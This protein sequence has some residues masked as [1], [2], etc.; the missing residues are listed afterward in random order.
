MRIVDIIKKPI[1]TEKNELWKKNAIKKQ[2]FDK[3]VFKVS[4]K[5][6]KPQIRQ[7]V[8]DLFAVEVLKVHTQILPI[9]KKR[10]RGSVAIQPKWKKAVITLSAGNKINFFEEI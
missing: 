9:R 3:V 7:A 8:E 6:S 1:I 2:D 10:I 4:I 5:A